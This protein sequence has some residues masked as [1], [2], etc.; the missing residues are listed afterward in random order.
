MTDWRRVIGFEQYTYVQSFPVTSFL[1]SGVSH[2]EDTIKDIHIGDTLDMSFEP[3]NIYDTSAIIIKNKTDIC[4]YVPKDSKDKVRPYVPS[5][6]KVIDKQ[7]VKNNIY[8]VRVDIIE[9]K[10]Q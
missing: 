6:V 1:V 9:E 4:G 2:Y 3:D 5:K 7:Y 10:S 8:S